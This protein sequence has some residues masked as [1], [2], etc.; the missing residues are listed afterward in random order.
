MRRHP[1]FFIGWLLAATV[2]LSL[3]GLTAEPLPASVV[4]ADQITD[5][6]AH[7]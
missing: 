1:I 7:C 6:G 5:H 3:A 2:L 4:G